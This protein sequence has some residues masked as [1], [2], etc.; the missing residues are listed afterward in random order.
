[1]DKVGIIMNGVT[2]RMGTQQHLER[3]I[4]AIRRQGGVQLQDGR[5]I[6]PDPVLLGRNPEKLE[7][8]ARKYEVERWSTASESCNVALPGIVCL[9][10]WTFRNRFPRGRSLFN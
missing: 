1:M 9:G 5:R 7:V 10:Y 4:V 2:G 3:S 6:L 8:F